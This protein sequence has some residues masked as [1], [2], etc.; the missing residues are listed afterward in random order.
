MKNI[1]TALKNH[2]AQGTTTLAHLVKMTRRD[3]A[4]L[5]VT[6]DHDRE[7]VLEGITYQPSFSVTGSVV[8]TS[9]QM[10]VDNMDARGALLAIGVN[11]E[12]IAAGLWDQCEVYVYRVNWADIS[13]GKE[14]IKRGTFGEISLGRGT[15]TNEVRGITQKL[16]QTLGEVVSP[17]CRADLFDSKCGITATEGVWKFSGVAVTSAESARQ[18]TASGLEQAAGFF[19]GGKVVWTGGENAGLIMEIREHTEGGVIRLQENMPYAIAAGDV[20]VFYAGCMK[21]FNEDC[22]AKFDNALRF[23]G[24]HALPGVDQIYRGP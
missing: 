18:F 24:F 7:L 5:A 19:D 11:E 6:L 20:G 22:K 2:M 4:V 3:G 13:Q 10:N 8:E 23:R 15:F 1:P 14:I 21:R 12:D 9:A 17:S 16:H